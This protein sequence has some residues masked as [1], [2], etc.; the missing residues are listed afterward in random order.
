VLA[1]HWKRPR[2]PA[3]HPVPLRATTRRLLAKRIRDNLGVYLL[4]SARAILAQREAL[5][6]AMPKRP[7][8]PEMPP[9]TIYTPP[10]RPSLADQLAKKYGITRRDS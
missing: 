3:G 7:L 9:T 4:T 8:K 2:Y 5:E 10:P 6:A 1:S